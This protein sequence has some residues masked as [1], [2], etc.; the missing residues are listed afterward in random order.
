M[1][2]LLIKGRAGQGVKS[3]GLI[4][5][6]ILQTQDYNMVLNFE[7]DSFIRS[8]KSS[9][10][11]VFSKKNTPNPLP[12]KYDKVYD[13]EEEKSQN[14]KFINIKVLERILTDLNIKVELKKYLPEKWN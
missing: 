4:L 7:Y 14:E 2:S 12:D 3:I 10:S 11:I 5:A 9:A 8:G 13:M 1:N 6:K